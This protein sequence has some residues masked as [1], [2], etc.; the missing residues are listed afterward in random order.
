MN[1]SKR[2][3]TM[4]EKTFAI[5]PAETTEDITA[6]RLILNAY[7]VVNVLPQLLKDKTTN[8]NIIFATDA[9]ADRL[10]GITARSEITVDLLA[11]DG[12]PIIEL[13]AHK[14]FQQQ[15][16]RTKRKAEVFTPSWLCNLMNNDCDEEWF[17]RPDVFNKAHG[18]IWNVNP[19]KV[20][21]GAKDDWKRY[22]ESRR[23]EITC[24]EAPYLVS[25]YDAS[26]GIMIPVEN[27]I[28][29]LDR[30]MRVVCENTNNFRDWYRWTKKAYQ[31]VYGYEYQG[32][33]LLIAR[34]NLLLTYTDYLQYRWKKEAKQKE[35]EEIAEIIVWNLWQ[36]DGLTK[37]VPMVSELIQPQ[38]DLFDDNRPLVE[39]SKCRC[40]IFDWQTKEKIFFA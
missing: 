31:S 21:F 15:A 5:S 22:V 25:R 29:M 30:K 37:L 34:I 28:G 14:S 4:A 16:S 35:L 20:E 13:R 12:Q 32:D 17:G 8:K 27:R 6:A 3:Y 19:N 36:M 7:P 38:Y 2:K 40:R 10:K 26:T 23:L 1:S 18:R 24:G 39:E 11:A 9:Y 33:N